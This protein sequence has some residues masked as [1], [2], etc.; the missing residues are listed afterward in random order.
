MRYFTAAIRRVQI[1]TRT[2]NQQKDKFN[3]RQFEFL[4]E[5][6][7][8]RQVIENLLSWKKKKESTKSDSKG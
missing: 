3:T 6:H 4:C 1:A 7:L 2:A 5:T 8:S